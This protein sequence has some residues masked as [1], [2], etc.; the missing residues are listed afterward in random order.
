VITQ[1][2]QFPRNGSIMPQKSHR[3]GS[4]SVNPAGQN[5]DSTRGS[6]F[7]IHVSRGLGV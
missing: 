6:L 3:E 4:D 2:S 7:C 5:A 1:L